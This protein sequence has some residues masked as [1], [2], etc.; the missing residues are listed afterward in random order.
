MVKRV[1]ILICLLTCALPARAQRVNFTD[2][3]RQ[4]LNDANLLIS[5]G[6][7][8]RARGKSSEA[9]EKF[10]SALRPLGEAMK[11]DPNNVEVLVTTGLCYFLLGNPSA[12]IKLLKPHQNRNE[13]SI[14]HQLAINYYMK[15][16]Y[17]NAVPL[18]RKVVAANQPDKYFDAYFLLGTYYY[19]QGKID[20]AEKPLEIYLKQKPDD[21]NARGVLGN[22]FLRKK[23]YKEA[24]EAF[25]AI[26]KL[27]PRNLRVKINVGNIWYQQGQYNKA[28]DLY[29]AI[30]RELKSSNRRAPYT[31]HFNLGMSYFQVKQWRKAE[32]QFNAFMAQNPRQG[33]QL[34]YYYLGNA[35]FEQRKYGPAKRNLL[36]AA[37]LSP[38]NPTT[39]YR[40]GVLA[41][42]ENRLDD[43]LRYLRKAHSL[44]SDD[45]QILF[46][47]GKIEL[48]KGK[49]E[50]ALSDFDKAIKL[51]P[52]NAAFHSYRA[53]VFYQ[54]KDYA[55]AA[56]GYEKALTLDP[57]RANARKGLVACLNLIASALLKK[58]KF[59]A[60]SAYLARVVKLDP[61]NK[62]ALTNLGVLLYEDKKYSQASTYLSRAYN[63]DKSND[64]L[65][66][67]YAQTLVAQKK[68]DEAA[69][70][71]RDAAGRVQSN[72]DLYY[73]IL[74]IVQGMQKK[75]DRAVDFLQKAKQA[76]RNNQKINTNLA[77][78]LFNRG[79]SYLQQGDVRKAA[80]DFLAALRNNPQMRRSEKGVMNFAAAFA[81]VY[82]NQNF[83]RALKLFE[84]ARAS[85]SKQEISQMFSADPNIYQAY[86]HYRLK[87]TS[88]LIGLLKDH[89]S[90]KVKGSLVQRMLSYSYAKL[91]YSAYSKGALEK[92]E[93]YLKQAL[94]MNPKDKILI[95]NQAVISYVRGQRDSAASIF[96]KLGQTVK[97]S[98]LNLGF[99]LDDQ[100]RDKRQAYLKYKQYVS[101]GGKDVELARRLM[102]VKEKIFAFQ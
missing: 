25:R 6:K 51:Q 26:L 33:K 21:V 81:L 70:V 56:N 50:D 65:L 55:R 44:K 97:E 93:Q 89:P 38:N 39:H 13:T 35:Q 1:A 80:A 96:Q 12:A 23:R 58:E 77:I 84:K 49:L 8:A 54:K 78:A 87:H 34:A 46:E 79:V 102:R 3:V 31:V 42:A 9:K 47:I 101:L 60:A 59:S 90:R 69:D 43:A 86:C 88:Q 52:S 30:L 91:A 71:L 45:P 76:G 100:K 24:I 73:N 19:K 95:H 61:K 83:D 28:I 40:L 68:L 57:K 92:A 17:A 16:D 82:S 20:E 99:Y 63:L 4:L 29:T 72:R 10:T 18:L 67:A 41:L 32:D 27:R 53:W 5:E 98:I 62:A 74:G 75:H 66:I 2:E 36:K 14:H 37:E 15:R 7:A 11:K 94:E 64:S 22:I 85:L 48:K